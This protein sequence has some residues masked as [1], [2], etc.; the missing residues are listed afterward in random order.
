MLIPAIFQK[1]LSAF[2]IY[3]AA[4]SLYFSC[5]PGCLW[6]IAMKGWLAQPLSI[7]AG[8][9]CPWYRELTNWPIII[10]NLILGQHPSTNLS[11]LTSGAGGFVVLLSQGPSFP[12]YSKSWPL[13]WKLDLQ[14]P[15][16]RQQASISGKFSFFCPIL[17]FVMFFQDLKSTLFISH[18]ISLFLVEH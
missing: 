10:H 15:H 9:A 17:T 13:N 11:A 14:T 1:S 5:S 2:V 8:R 6:C 16:R 3:R 4:R 12:Q 7:P 18:Q